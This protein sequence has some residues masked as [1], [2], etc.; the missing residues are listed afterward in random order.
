MSESL[1]TRTTTVR[2][3]SISGTP[4]VRY[5]LIN[6][7]TR[8]YT[9]GKLPRGELREGIVALLGTEDNTK[10]EMDDDDLLT[11]MA[12]HDLYVARTPAPDGAYLLV[13]PG[14]HR[15]CDALRRASVGHRA[16]P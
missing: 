10:A 16:Q 1:T 6:P 11:I 8:T 5:V 15:A 7:S 13:S 9:E 14:A 12:L 2:C 3:P 4:E